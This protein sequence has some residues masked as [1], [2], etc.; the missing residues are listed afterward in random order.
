MFGEVVGG[1]L[2]AGF[3]PIVPITYERETCVVCREGTDKS[4][5][6]GCVKWGHVVDTQ[7][8]TDALKTEAMISFSTK[9]SRDFLEAMLK[10][11]EQAFRIGGD[12]FW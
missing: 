8:R 5:F 6:Y 2:G 10:W 1:M 12:V 11:N 3:R 7:G 9:P 4:R